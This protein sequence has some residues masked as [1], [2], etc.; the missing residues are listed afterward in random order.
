MKDIT[1]KIDLIMTNIKKDA[2]RRQLPDLMDELVRLSSILAENKRDLDKRK[3]KR[4]YFYITK[5]ATNRSTME[6]M[7]KQQAKAEWRKPRKI[8]NVEVEDMTDLEYVNP[9]K[10][11]EK[12]RDTLEECRQNV[13]YIEPLIRSYFER[14]NWIKF[15]DRNN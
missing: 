10:W 4:D 6:G 11:E 7:E 15:L 2:S 1:D 5:K 14:C 12:I 3:S 9:Q 13:S 8:T